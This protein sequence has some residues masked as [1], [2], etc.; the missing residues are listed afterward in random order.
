MDTGA[1]TLF[2][3]P[4]V[5]PPRVPAS[6]SRRSHTRFRLRQRVIA[7][8]NHSI[9]ALNQLSCSFFD[10]TDIPLDAGVDFSFV[11]SPALAIPSPESSTVT[12]LR[13]DSWLMFNRVPSGLLAANLILYRVRAATL[14]LPLCHRSTPF[15]PYQVPR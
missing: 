6:R 2:P 8:T 11:T 5:G 7:T 1:G 14:V 12:R 4:G 10:P 13:R 15:P 3:L 9:S